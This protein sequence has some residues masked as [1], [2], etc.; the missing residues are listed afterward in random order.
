MKQGNPFTLTFGK[1]P[2]LYLDRYENT[3]EI[4]SAFL[5]DNPI[6]QT[7]LISGVRGSGKTVLM[8]AVA[9][10]L[11]ST[12][13]WIAVDLN[14]TQPLLEELAM[15]LTDACKPLPDALEKGFEL[16]LV[17]FGVA[18]SGS[19]EMHDSV[20]RIEAILTRLKKQ[21][22]RVL[23]TIDEAVPDEHM[24]R[25]A[26]QFQILLRQNYP[27]FLI[28]TGLYENIYGIQN[29]PALTFLLRTPKINLGPLGINQIKNEYQSIF[30]LDD[31]F[32]TQMANLTMGYAFAFQALGLLYWE[33]RDTL[34]MPQIL[35]KLDAM[36]EDFV[37]RKLWSSLTETEQRIL[38]NMPPEGQRIKLS[39]LC[40]KLQV[41]S[42]S[43]SKYRERLISK[44]FC[45]SPSY[46]YL[47]I[48][49]PRFQ[50]ITRAYI[51]EA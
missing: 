2:N 36:L 29:D 23:I 35:Q 51:T 18:Y 28:L 47:M 44:G 13:N 6:S 16:S 4:L 3:N 42:T 26:S 15:R 27:V 48:V 22:K 11:R 1:Q 7:Y 32:S 14:S 50:T 9:N 17:G 10:T 5:S 38:Q 25:F 31:A 8:T 39:A 43:I 12:A 37:Y 40:E 49:L 21:N 24:R 20:S 30:S 45:V 19:N 46:G 33:Y 34:S 41:K